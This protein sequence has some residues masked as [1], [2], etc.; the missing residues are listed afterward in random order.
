MKTTPASF[1]KSLLYTVGAETVMVVVRGD[2]DVNEV[3]LANA[4]GVDEVFLASEADVRK[5]TGANVGFA[6]PVGFSGKI[7][8]DAFAAAIDEG[9]CGANKTDYHVTGIQYGRN[10]S[11]DLCD[12]R[13]VVDGDPCEKCG[14]PLKLYRGIEGGH[15]FVLGTK[16][17]ET[18]GATYLDEAGKAKAIVMGCY[19]IGVS[20]LVASAVE[21]H[22]DDNGIVWPMAIAPFHV[23]IA[24]LGEEPE[25]IEAVAKLESELEAKGIEVLVDDRA[26]RPG[27][28]FKDADLI[29]VPLRV[30][31]GARALA[32]GGV[33][34][35]ARTETNP[36]N[37]E[38]VP[39]AEATDR[40]IADVGR[41]LGA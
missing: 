24:Q 2:H 30:T 13:S 16:Y 14:A 23:H 19:G 18:M 1:L 20:R 7:L 38:L 29:G 40:I 3:K 17:S 28:K 34:L 8:I 39:L 21:Q 9:V 5:A 11:G 25:V 26:V 6:G 32:Q 35:K 41:E 31:V 15:I 10:F 33:E 12:L 4:L 27:V 22:N 36:K 37:A